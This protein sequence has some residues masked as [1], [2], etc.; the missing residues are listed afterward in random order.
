[1]KRNRS[2]NFIHN[3]NGETLVEIIVAFMVLLIVVALFTAS[4]NSASAA[5]NN[6]TDIRRTSDREYSAYRS[7]LANEMKNPSYT[8]PLKTG[9]PPVEITVTGTEG[10]ITL[11]AQQYSSGDSVYWVF[12]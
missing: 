11:S 5:V 6:S 3:N 2:E 8:N 1:M 7:G 9:Q 12:K 4:I 10:N